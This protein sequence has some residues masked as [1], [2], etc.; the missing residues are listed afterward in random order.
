MCSANTAE[1]IEMS[2]GGL[3]PAGPRNDSCGSKEH[4]LDGSISDE[5]IRN[6]EG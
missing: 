2:F 1:P 5:S 6:H 4:V 3:T